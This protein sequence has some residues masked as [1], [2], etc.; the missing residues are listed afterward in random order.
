MTSDARDASTN[1]APPPDQ[2]WAYEL[3][4]IKY[5]MFFAG[6]PSEHLPKVKN[7]RCEM[8]DTI[9]C[10]YPKSGTHWTLEIVSM[11][12][13]RKATHT[14]KFNI[15][16]I[17]PSVALDVIPSPRIFASHLRFHQ[18]PEQFRRNRSK[19]IYCV[20]NP[21][22]V[23]VSLYTFSRANRDIHYTGTW[24]Q[25]LKDFQKG[26]VSYSSWF[27]H[28]RSWEKAKEA[29]G[30]YPLLVLHYEDLRKDPE[31][32]IRKIAKFLDV[33]LDSYTLDTMIDKTSL[34]SMRKQSYMYHPYPPE[35]MDPNNQQNLYRKGI[36][37]DWKRWFTQEQNQEFDKIFDEKMKGSS[38]KLKFQLLS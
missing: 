16:D 35:V 7:M 17:I 19:L 10:S 8:D 2:L 38:L 23:A 20:R 5:P 24:E 33:P 27:D 14:A 18:L 1:G 34:E 21:K 6:H 26:N 22:D 12:I 31:K 30:K 37:G 9:V 29:D 13:R 36:V 11:L 3:D 25:F 32:E 15:L 4:G 28:V